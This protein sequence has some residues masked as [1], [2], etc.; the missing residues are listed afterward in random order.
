M[1]VPGTAHIRQHRNLYDRYTYCAR[2]E[3]YFKKPCGA[4]C[5]CCGGRLRFQSKFRF[6]SKKRR[7]AREAAKLVVE[8]KQY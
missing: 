6:R 1:R 2:C 5:V 3:I 4:I 8:V 7:E